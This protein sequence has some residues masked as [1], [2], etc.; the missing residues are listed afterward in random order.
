[1]RRIPSSCNLSLLENTRDLPCTVRSRV[2]LFLIRTV[3]NTVVL[4]VVVVH[5]KCLS[6]IGVVYF[7][8]SSAFVSPT[9][10]AL[11]YGSTY[12]QFRQYGARISSSSISSESFQGGSTVKSLGTT[13]PGFPSSFQQ[14]TSTTRINDNFHRSSLEKRLTAL[15]EHLTVQDQHQQYQTQEPCL[16]GEYS[17]LFRIELPEG[18]CVGISLRLHPKDLFSSTVQQEQEQER[19]WHWLHSYLHPEEIT[20]GYRLKEGTARNTFF[21]GRLAIR[22]ALFYY[23]MSK[24]KNSNKD[25]SSSELQQRISSLVLSSP[26]NNIRGILGGEEPPCAPLLQGTTSVSILKDKHG[27]PELPRGFLGSISHK[28]NIGV[29][30]VSTVD[31]VEDKRNTRRRGIGVDIEKCEPRSSRIARRVLT[32][33]EIESLGRLPVRYFSENIS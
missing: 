17:Q 10:A 14:Q 3:I 31:E 24:T 29:A 11:R 7:A 32:P 6:T 8:S 27:R 1:M 15:D 4:V 19:K 28:D 30:L 25:R 33:R 22:H 26:S 12:R 16:E 13:S 23:N 9:M 21:L 2:P 5:G 20:F 18:Y